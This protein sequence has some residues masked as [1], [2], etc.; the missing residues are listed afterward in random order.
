MTRIVQPSWMPKAAMRRIIT[1]WTCGRHSANSVDRAHYHILIEGGGALVRGDHSIADNVSTGD[2]RYAAHTL[3]ANTAG[4]G[5][6]LCGM[7]DC[8]EEPF[9]PGPYPITWEQW[10]T[11]ALVIAD[12]CEAYNIDVSPTTVLGHGEVQTN[13]GIKQRGKWDPLVLP[14]QQGWNRRQVGEQMRQM[15]REALETSGRIVPGAAVTVNVGGQPIAAPLAYIEDGETWVGV[16]AAVGALGGRV[17]SATD[18]QAEVQIGGKSARLEMVTELAGGE[19]RGFVPVR[20]L[21]AAAGLL[22]HWDPATRTVTLR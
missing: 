1:H 13:L 8:R 4:I 3:G 17:P 7:M 21:A 10:K 18:G 14:W 16:R 12:L 19:W 15:A 11:L 22:P 5:V 2:G 9:S 20:A 6:A